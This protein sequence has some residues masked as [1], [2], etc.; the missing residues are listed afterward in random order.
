METVKISDA[1]QL[2][3]LVKTLESIKASGQDIMSQ[4]FDFMR[5]RISKL[6]KALAGN[7]SAQAAEKFNATLAASLSSA[8]NA[9]W[10]SQLATLA[11]TTGVKLL[12]T[13]E[14]VLDAEGKQTTHDVKGVAT[15]AF[16]I[17]FAAA[18]AGG[19]SSGG[20]GT[21]TKAPA[22]YN[23]YVITSTQEAQDK[24]GYKAS[25]TFDTGAKARDYSLNPKGLTE[26]AAKGL[27]VNP[28]NRAIGYGKA[29]SAN[30]TLETLQ[31]DAG[32]KAGGVTITLSNIAEAAPVA[33]A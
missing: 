8:K 6:Q 19:T 32:F 30:A 29:A 21:G 16:T 4:T 15:P 14:P 20:N 5:E 18:G 7:S 13:C 31:K 23:N 27:E 9:E 11:G 25:E 24:Y 1:E 33:T 12:V 22:K 3:S 26:E 28:G 10:L 2:D 17:K